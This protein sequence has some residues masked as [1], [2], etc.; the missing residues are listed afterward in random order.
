MKQNRKEKVLEFIMEYSTKLQ[1][2]E[3]PKFTTN[4]LSEKLNMQRTNLSSILNQLVKE[5]RLIKHNGR[6]VLYQFVDPNTAQTDCFKELIGY[7]MSLKEAV[8]LAKAAVLYPQGKS[9]ILLT[10]ERGSGIRYF[11]E[12]I[13]KFAVKSGVIKTGAPMVVFDCKTY[14]ENPEYIREILFGIEKK[15]GLLQTTK[16]GILLI[17]NAELLTGYERGL[18][19]SSKQHGILLCSISRNLEEP[20]FRL[21]KD[22]ADFVIDILPLR[23]RSFEEKFAFVTKFF[24]EEAGRMQRNIMADTSILHA[25]LLYEAADNI[26]GLKNDVHTGCANCYARAHKTTHRFI[27]VLFS[28]FPKSVRKGIIY[29]KKHKDEINQIISNDCK[30]SF[31]EKEI[32]KKNKNQNN[33]NIYQLLDASKK[34]LKKQEISEEEINSIVSMKLQ[35]DF[36]NYFETLALRGENR[37]HLEKMVSEKLIYEVEKFIKKAEKELDETIDERLFCALCLHINACIVKVSTKQRIS[38]EEISRIVESYPMEYQLAKDFTNKIQQE[39]KV[40]MNIDEIIFVILFLLQSE[41]CRKQMVVTLLAM[42]GNGAATAIAE[43]INFMSREHTTYAYDLILEK[44]VQTAYEE[45]MQKM[46]DIHQGKGILLIYDMGSIR[47]MAEA[48]SAETKIPVKFLEMPLHLLG[49]AASNK[50]SD[51]NNLEDIHEYLL[52]NF[53]DICYSSD[54]R[55]EE[56]LAILSSRQEEETKLPVVEPEEHGID[57]AFEYLESQFHEFDMDIMR[58]YLIS[59][60]SQMECLMSLVLDEDKKIGLIV[61]IVCLVDKIKHQQIPSVNFTASDII[62]KQQELV[63][64]VKRLLKPLEQ[65]F[66]IYINDVEAAIIISIMQQ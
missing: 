11:A 25:L 9:K 21:F 28:D 18:L 24:Q 10:A 6:P 31:T 52:T 27:E 35:A 4:F 3:Y 40:S 63:Q 5:G 61:H 30:Y 15:E 56:I 47:T 55:N 1:H 44:N 22:E 62:G 65:E 32:L 66:D 45:L 49:V 33:H 57:E 17:K 37:T 7:E 19:F 34:E 54:E 51:L 2:D 13:F 38:N 36:Q 26:R 58:A 14:M 59:F 41:R 16:D 43:V 12:M 42:H 23:E 60:I 46:I 48:I 20:V 53:Q 8:T 29:F 39:F 64:E 50:S